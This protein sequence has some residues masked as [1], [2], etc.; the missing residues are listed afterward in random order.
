MENAA[1]DG[2]GYLAVEFGCCCRLNELRAHFGFGAFEVEGQ[3]F[4]EELVV[5][6][7]GVPVVG[8][9]DGGVE[10]TVG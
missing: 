1:G 2:R 5:G 7:G 4:F 8:G 3:E 9:E 6:E 10:A